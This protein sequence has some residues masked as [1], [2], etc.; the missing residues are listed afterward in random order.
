MKIFIA[1]YLPLKNKGEEAIV[2]GLES[3]FK[4]KYNED[5]EFCVL[6]VVNESER[7]GNVDVLPSYYCY[8]NFSNP[9]MRGF[10]GSL[11]MLIMCCITILGL[12]PYR[13]RVK[14]SLLPKIKECDKVLLAHDGFMNPFCAALGLYLHT[15]GIDYSIIGAGFVPVK[16]KLRWFYRKVYSSFFNKAALVV[17][18]EQTAFEYVNSIS[19]NNNVFMLPDPAFNS[20]IEI[21]NK[22]NANS[23][24][25]KYGFSRKQLNIGV[26]VCENSISFSTA[27]KDSFNKQIDHREFIARLLDSLSEKLGCNFYFLPHCIENGA[28]DDLAIAQDVVKRITKHQHNVFI[29]S[30]DLPVM[31]IKGVISNMDMIIG[32]RTHS[33]INSISCGVPFLNLTCSADIRSHDIIEK[34]CGLGDYILDLDVPALTDVIT[35]VINVIENREIV[36]TQLEKINIK[37]DNKFDTLINRI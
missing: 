36:R 4:K 10:K 11:M 18:R 35:A 12:Y 19:S 17:L 27:F 28:G 37:N 34:D 33:I 7:V 20:K 31:D 30:E 1:D 9:K 26:T 5:V 22:E 6:D 8:P 29:I 25:N 32:E 16:G 2:R 14:Q 21:K 23:V 13:R 15:Q 3:L 24:L